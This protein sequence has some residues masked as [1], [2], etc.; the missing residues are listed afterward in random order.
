MFSPGLLP[1]ARICS[2]GI[3]RINWLSLYY[4]M[5]SGFSTWDLLGWKALQ[6]ILNVILDKHLIA[7][8]TFRLKFRKGLSSALYVVGLSHDCA[9]VRT[10]STS[11]VNTATSLLQYCM[12]FAYSVTSCAGNPT[13]QF[14]ESCPELLLWPPFQMSILTAK[15]RIQ[16]QRPVPSALNWVQ[17]FL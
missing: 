14:I 3:L 16:L 5:N 17:V 13:A 4:G 1:G 11:I 6:R 12:P 9:V 10:T 8:F 2:E 7:K 15:S